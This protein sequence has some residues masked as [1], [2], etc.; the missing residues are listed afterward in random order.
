[1]SGPSPG[2]LS[3][4]SEELV[5]GGRP[6]GRKLPRPPGTPTLNPTTPSLA[7]VTLDPEILID[8][9]LDSERRE[10][11][12]TLIAAKGLSGLNLRYSFVRIQLLPKEYVDTF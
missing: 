7:I 6:G 8:F 9:N 11:Q 2:H 10:L 12:V 5:S 4:S 3:H 1:M